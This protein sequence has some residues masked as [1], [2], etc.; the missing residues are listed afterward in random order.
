MP[1]EHREFFTVDL[2]TGWES[3]PGYPPG[4]Q[5]KILSGELD[6]VGRRGIRTRLL[7]FLPGAHTDIPFEHEYWEEVNV[8]SGDLQ[9]GGHTFRRFTHACRPPHV[10]HGPFASEQGCLLLELHYFGSE[11]RD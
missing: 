2:E 7:R 8:L 3:P 4:I 11:I 9:V 6:E 10:P 5:Q 1:K